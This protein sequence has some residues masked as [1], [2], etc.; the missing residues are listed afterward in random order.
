M[1]NRELQSRLPGRPAALSFSWLR[2]LPDLLA[3]CAFLILIPAC[4]GDSAA[5]FRAEGQKLLKEGNAN[6]AVVFFKNA[7]EKDPADFESRLSLA[8]A[9]IQLGKLPQA[10]DELQKN[11][12]QRPADPALNVELAAFQLLHGKPAQALEYLQKAET[13]GKVTAET[14]EMAGAA[15]AMLGKN[16]AAEASLRKSLE[17]DPGRESASISLVRVY[18][19][20]QDPAKALELCDA[21]VAANPKSV[22]ALILRAELAQRMNDAGRA[23]DLY[24]KAAEISPKDENIRYMLGSLLLQLGKNSEAEAVIASM[25]SDYKSSARLFML[26]GMY[27]YQT[28]KFKEAA[29]FFQNSIDLSPSLEGYYRLGLAQNRLGN[30]ESAISQLRKVLDFSPRHA[31]SLRLMATILLEQGRTED[32]RLEAEKLLQFYPDD[33][34]AHY[35]MGMALAAAGENAKA[36]AEFKRA[37]EL[38]PEMSEASLRRGS[39]LIAEGR[40]QEAKEDLAAA[41]RQNAD[42][43]GARIALFQF[44]LGRRNYDEA[45]KLVNEGL[46]KQSKNAVLLT[47]RAQLFA[48]RNKTAEAL[49]P[50]RQAREVD[51]DMLD[52][53]NLEMRLHIQAGQKEKALEAC[54]A[55][56]ARHPEATAQ[57]IA[58]AALLDMAGKR[59]EATTTLQKA[60][61]LGEK[62][63][64]FVLMQRALA[65]KNPT[66]AKTLLQKDLEAAPTPVVRDTLAKLYLAEKNFDAA[67]A[68]YESLEKTSASEAALGKFRL[69]FT[70]GKQQDALK[71]ARRLTEIDSSSFLGALCAAEVL[72]RMNKPQEAMKELDDAYRRLQKPA[73]LTAMAQSCQRRGEWEKA[74]AYYQTALNLNPKDQGALSGKALLLMQRR[75]YTEAVEYYERVQ[76]LA[77]ASAMVSNNLAMAYAESGQNPERALQMASMAFMLQPENPQVLDTLGS[78]LLLNKRTNDATKLL[79]DAVAMHPT[80]AQLYYRLGT[81]L[82]QAQKPEEAKTALR[83][84]LELG[85]FDDADKARKLLQTM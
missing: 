58:S 36:L 85:N 19:A 8:K 84:S 81:A 47:L 14:R 49:A 12:R 43:L 67:W 25:R 77:P 71:Q 57:L 73:L 64:L 11:L 31:A 51:P 10:E 44:Q 61:A 78:C 46:E 75:R 76:R 27:A 35:L 68:L 60:Y 82:S 6:G 66:E 22:K 45:E 79:T 83:K 15:Y 65:A 42:N 37:T 13:G 29:G 2:R 62:R 40:Y 7:L 24:R 32:A 59:D 5:E 9:Y 3:V 17:L 63:A 69:L 56:L 50:V 53:L 38:N 21:M 28:G 52:A 34:G 80:S 72:E 70:T 1:N 55:Y 23:L 41:V 48:V 39:I 18:L 33:A 74:D 4:S 26:E 16:D 30:R 20:K 54:Q